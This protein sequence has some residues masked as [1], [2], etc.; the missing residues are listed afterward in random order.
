MGMGM[1]MRT[2]VILSLH[3]KKKHLKTSCL[4]N[5]VV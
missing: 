4:V 1:G 2:V 3:E 5:N